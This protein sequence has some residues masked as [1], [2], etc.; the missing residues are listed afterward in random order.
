MEN[1][2]LL[3]IKDKSFNALRKIFGDGC[4]FHMHHILR[5][6]CKVLF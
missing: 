6:K 1:T 3:H 5:V 2:V 4:D